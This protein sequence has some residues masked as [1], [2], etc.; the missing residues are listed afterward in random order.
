MTPN[1]VGGGVSASIWSMFIM[2]W[3]DLRSVA[4]KTMKNEAERNQTSKESAYVVKLNFAIVR[5]CIVCF[6]LVFQSG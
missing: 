3:H 5:N 1:L 4:K 2:F 6:P